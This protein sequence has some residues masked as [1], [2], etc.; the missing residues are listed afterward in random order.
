MRRVNEDAPPLD[1][2]RTRWQ[3]VAPLLAGIEQD[4]LVALEQ[5]SAIQDEQ[6]RVGLQQA[7]AWGI[8]RA[9]AL[10]HNAGRKAGSTLICAAADL[11]PEQ[12]AL[13]FGR[14][15]PDGLV[16]LMHALAVHADGDVRRA[17]TIVDDLLHR[18]ANPDLARAARRITRA[19]RAQPSAP[20][21]QLWLGCGTSLV[22]RRHAHSDGSYVATLC[23]CLFYVP[24]VP[25]A[26]Y[27]VR[28][29][30]P[31]RY[32]FLAP[33]RFT[34]AAAVARA[35]LVVGGVL[36]LLGG[37]GLVYYNSPG[38]RADRAIEAVRA[39]VGEQPPSEAAKTWMRFL[40]SAEG[41]T[42]VSLR[43]EAVAALVQSW[44][45]EVPAPFTADNLVDARRV[46]TDYLA[47][48]EPWRGVRGARPLL[49]AL[50][51][52]AEAVPEDKDRRALL[53]FADEV[54]TPNPPG[55]LLSAQ[56]S[57]GLVRGDLWR[58]QRSLEAIGAYAWVLERPEAPAKSAELV[59]QASLRWSL[60]LEER[61]RLQEWL[62]KA[63]PYPETKPARDALTQALARSDALSESRE[64][65]ERLEAADLQALRAWVQ[66]DPGDAEA[67]VQLAQAIASTGDLAEAEQTILQAAR[68]EWL[69][70]SEQG[71]LAQIW[72]GT[73]RSVQAE[74][75]LEA[76]I[77]RRLPLLRSAQAL[78]RDRLDLI[79]RELDEE[80]ESG[81]VPERMKGP[82]RTR[83][84]TEV[85]AAYDEELAQRKANDPLLAQRRRTYRQASTVID[86]AIDVG[87]MK[88]QRANLETGAQRARLL[89]EAERAFLAGAEAAGDNPDYHLRLGTVFYRLGKSQAGEQQF[90]RVLALGSHGW[91][92]AVARAYRELDR[93]WRARA[94]AERVYNDSSGSMADAAAGLLAHLARTVESEK[95]WLERV[96]QP[97]PG[98]QARLAGTRA[99]L[100]SRDLKFAQAA[101]EYEAEYQ[102]WLSLGEDSDFA[103]NNRAL[104]LAR[105]FEETGEHALLVRAVEDLGK[106]VRLQPDSSIAL[107]NHSDVLAQLAAT[108]LLKRWIDPAQLA[109]TGRTLQR[110]LTRL[111]TGPL[112][113]QV[114]EISAQ[115]RVLESGQQARRARL[116][117]PGDTHGY[118]RALLFAG[119]RKSLGPLKD[120][121]REMRQ[122]LGV[123]DASIEAPSDS[124]L[125]VARERV[126]VAE[127]RLSR[128]VDS[129]TKAVA[130][131]VLAL[132]QEWLGA[133]TAD[134]EKI[135][136]A[137]A[138][139]ERAA[140]AWPALDLRRDLFRMRLAQALLES[141]SPEDPLRTRFI[142]EQ[143]AMAP[144]AAALMLTSEQ[145]QA[146]FL[147]RFAEHPIMQSISHSVQFEG[148]DDESFDR[149]AMA[150][151][152]GQDELRDRHRAIL[153]SE[154]AQL[155]LE[156]EARLSSAFS[157][158]KRSGL[159]AE[160]D[161]LKAPPSEPAP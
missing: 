134:P 84:Q 54:L 152:F 103:L 98:T 42:R 50:R 63:E 57:F 65:N 70:A 25:L 58:A 111:A 147:K 74:D 61:L 23:L 73:G 159:I 30:R 24:I 127:H 10:L 89:Q 69:T 116:L 14:T 76:Q 19:A 86:T 5:L 99:A 2:S 12:P 22:G 82:M 49:E 157:I 13:R 100:A 67:L 150:I 93:D 3:D 1:P 101:K 115:P 106:S 102:I 140:T 37:C 144:A 142:N 155:L 6:D 64:R 105:R 125:A 71:L 39:E 124:A 20:E 56:R 141:M 113:A 107:Q 52:W 45:A 110:T 72:V 4:A 96:V 156:L 78:Y 17:E 7:A 128:V 60:V 108:D 112:R 126:V 91:D 80:I 138:S 9:G 143:W 48:P 18:D 43:S 32:R 11:D 28:E 81:R 59:E 87:G 109:L 137:Q 38:L 36:G 146:E 114:R 51:A 122:H 26:A 119:L 90:G 85:G 130:L 35:G 154:R 46:T 129:E 132:E 21:P 53:S 27:R 88:L 136:A 79:E 145:T 131:L 40:N 75:L 83:R 92:L 161:G 34:R 151:I 15:D 153:R 55:A 123:D 139:A 66:R 77:S 31:G 62:Q 16:G 68:P 29:H 135:K 158:Q 148:P 33:V 117:A 95:T 47:L 149:W 41:Q 118:R 120:L 160:G 104:A 94:I 133:R 97:S 8:A 44:I 121:G